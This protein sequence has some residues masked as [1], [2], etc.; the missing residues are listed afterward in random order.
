MPGG[1]TNARGTWR[2]PSVPITSIVCTSWRDEAA[3]ERRRHVARSRGFRRRSRPPHCAGAA[4]RRTR[5]GA[6][7]GDEPRGADAVAAEIEEG[8]AAE[9]ACPTHVVGTWEEPVKVACTARSS[10]TRGS[11][12]RQQRSLPRVSP[13]V[14]LREHET[15]SLRLVV[16]LVD[17]LG[18]ARV[19]LLAD[20]VLAGCEGAH[21]PLVMERVRERD[22]DR[23]DAV[24]RRGAPR[25]RRAPS[26]CRARGRRPAPAR[27][28]AN[29]RRRRRTVRPPPAHRGSPR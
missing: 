29:R 9:V 4:C 20:D 6:P 5:S 12:S 2:T 22:V 1:S 28:R 21:R 23:V 24:V 3:L 11:S 13:H 26:R 10:P 14:A 15:V 19:R 18:T 25:T 27:R 17:F 8:A 7:P 16:R